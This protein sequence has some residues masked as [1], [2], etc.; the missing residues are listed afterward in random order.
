MGRRTLESYALGQIKEAFEHFVM[1][2]SR[3]FDASYLHQIIFFLYRNE[4]I[5]QC[6]VKEGHFLLPLLLMFLFNR[7]LTRSVSLRN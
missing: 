7:F 2:A 5:D 4:P 3:M 1:K 6:A